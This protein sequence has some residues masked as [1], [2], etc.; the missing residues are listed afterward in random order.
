MAIQEAIQSMFDFI[1]ED[2]N[3]EGL[4]D[5]P[6]RVMQS[7]SHIFGGYKMD[8]TMILESAIFKEGVCDEM[9]VLKNVEFYSMCEHHF[10]PFFGHISIG[11]I[12]NNKFVGISKL[13]RLVEVY[14]RRLQIQENMTS[15]IADTIMEVLQPKGVMVI[16]HARHMCMKMRG[17]ETQDSVMITSAV[18]GLFKSDHR[19]REEFM[20]HIRG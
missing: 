13:A 19:T 8:P 7:W 18:R 14:S 1:G 5:T 2:R 9:V 6:K 17:V 12:P 11:Y 15:Q 3:R 16:V 20:G 4:I 10:L